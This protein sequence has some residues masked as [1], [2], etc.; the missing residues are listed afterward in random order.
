MLLLG[1]DPTEPVEA[2]AQ[3]ATDGRQSREGLPRGDTGNSPPV[4]AREGGVKVRT[5]RAE[6]S[7]EGAVWVDA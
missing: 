6:P 4:D 3:T 2:Q 5:G 1:T 7:L